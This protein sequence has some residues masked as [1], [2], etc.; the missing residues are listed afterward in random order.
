MQRSTPQARLA[1]IIGSEATA[2]ATIERLREYDSFNDGTTKMGILS[3]PQGLMDAIRRH[4]TLDRATATTRLGLYP[5][6][7]GELPEYGEVEIDGRVTFFVDPASGKI[8]FC[9]RPAPRRTD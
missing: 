1:R 8:Y 9:Q 4:R 2:L 5:F 3:G 6:A 7:N